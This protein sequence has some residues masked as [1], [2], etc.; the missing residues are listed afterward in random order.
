MRS[1]TFLRLAP[2]MLSPAYQGAWMRFMSRMQNNGV[3]DYQAE[4]AQNG[5]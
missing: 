5:W 4:D 1:L 2:E 3:R